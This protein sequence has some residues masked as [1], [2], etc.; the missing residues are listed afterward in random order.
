[1]RWGKGHVNFNGMCN[2]MH[3]YSIVWWRSTDLKFYS[4]KR[5]AKLVLTKPVV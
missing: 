4:F 3:M 2:G 1:M 5:R